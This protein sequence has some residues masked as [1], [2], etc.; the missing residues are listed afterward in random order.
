MTE[1]TT[2]RAARRRRRTTGIAVGL[3]G[4]LAATMLGSAGATAAPVASAV[5]GADDAGLV[6]WYPLDAASTSGGT[7]ANLAAGSTFGAATVNGAQATA[8]GLTLDGTDDY[9]DLPDDILAGLTDATVSLDVLVATDQATP[10]FIYGLGNSS[11]SNGNGYLFTTGNAYRTSIAT[12]NWSTEQTVT[13]GSNLTRGVWKTLTY[14]LSGTTATLYEDGVQVEQATNVTTDPGQIGAGATTANYVGRSLYSGDRYLK[15]QVRDFRLYDRAVTA[16]EAA[17]L[18]TETS[19][20]AVD[21]DAA[22]LD[23]G[24]TSAVTADL[25]LPTAAAQGSLVTWSSSDPA[26]VSATGD[27]TRP[28][29]GEDDATVTLTALLTRGAVARTVTFE[30]TV[31]AELDA[32]EAAQWDAEHVSIP[33]LD[34]VRGNIT[35]PDEGVNGSSLTWVSGD[36]ATISPTGEVTRPASGEQAVVV[37]LTVTA[38]TDGETATHVYEAT[39]LPLP[40]EADY[41]GYFFPYF[42]GES[43]PDGESV[44]FSVSDGNDPLDWIELN[45]G[46]PVLTS[47]LGE[48]G[49]RDP[50]IIRSPEGD[51]FYLLATDLRI[52][53]G[54]DFGNAQERGSLNL[55]I[56]E[57]TDLVHWSDQRAVKV[58]SDYAG[59]T[60]APE[61][62]YDA[63]RG[64]Y[65]VYWA[66]ALY[67][68]TETDGRRISTSYQRMM[69]ATTRDFVTFTEPQV[70]IDEKRGN[71]LGMIDSSI[72]EEDGTYYRFTKDEAYMIP[73]LE[74]STD[75]RST[76]WE[77]VA[78][79]IGLGQPNP[80]GGTFTNGEGPTAFRSNTEEKWYLFMD[81]PSYHGGQGYM[82]FESTDLDS[83]DWTSV[84]AHLPT[85]PRHGTVLPI[86]AAEQA[87]VLAA[88]GDE[89]PAPELALDVQVVPRC[90]AGKAYVAV[91]ATNADEVPVDIALSTPYGAKSFADVAPGKN[92]YQSF[93][94]RAPSAAAAGV[95]VTATGVVEGETVT[96]TEA[97]DFGAVDCA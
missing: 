21:A 35:L 92:A 39:V 14:T 57:S 59:N 55:M 71:G 91:R 28:A 77:L 37:Q 27:V 74:R 85:S 62:F 11:G 68:T 26:V 69:Y 7:T 78:E 72:V 6:A 41:E 76:D 42:E 15:G 95:T 17:E 31:L 19:T 47:E 82:A 66:S 67:P 65:I 64:E 45:E 12:G 5:G 93:A 61:A 34:D 56:W 52:Y 51:R 81:Q 83:G 1:E 50:F 75:L 10:Y 89:P 87:A 13:K 88:Y 96:S 73:R 16:A 43:T 4:A 38:S 60:W 25:V 9:V 8:D 46:E 40:A 30:V 36:T 2:R 63:Q 79:K 33:N 44:Y 20:A 48:K 49:L 86:T 3:V 22:T 53:G 58:S 24:V 54:N 29:A 80:W 97:L 70:W 90:L 84:D 32:A 94:V 18:A 23:L